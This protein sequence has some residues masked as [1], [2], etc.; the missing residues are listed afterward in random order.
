MDLEKAV[1]SVFGSDEELSEVHG[2]EQIYNF[3]CAEGYISNMNGAIVLAIKAGTHKGH[4]LERDASVKDLEEIRDS[5]KQLYSVVTNLMS[6]G[7][8]FRYNKD[9]DDGPE[10]ESKFKVKNQAH[11][12]KVLSDVYNA[13]NS[14][15]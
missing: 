1:K 12:D 4:F 11:L 15:K 10:F 14:T 9:Y 2:D 13:S 6:R 3:S 7:Y 8:V 5:A